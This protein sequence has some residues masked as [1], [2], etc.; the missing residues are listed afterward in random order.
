MALQT[1]LDYNSDHSLAM[2]VGADVT[3]SPA[4]SEGSHCTSKEERE[5]D[6]SWL[7]VSIAHISLARIT[8]LAPWH[9]SRRKLYQIVPSV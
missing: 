5:H 7:F 2:S 8:T 9:D 4:A 1:V 3:W 6:L